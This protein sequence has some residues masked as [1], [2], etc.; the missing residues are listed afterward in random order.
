MLTGCST[1]VT[2][3]KDEPGANKAQQPSDASV[4][5]KD[6][7]SSRNQKW[8]DQACSRS[9]G[10]SLWARCV[11]RETRAL[12]DGV[13]DISQLSVENQDWISSSCPRSLGPS[14]A[15]RC[16]Q[17]EKEAVEAGIPDGSTLSQE[18]KNWLAQSCSKSLGPSLF[19]A[20]MNREIEALAKSD[21]L[22][23]R[24]PLQT[25]SPEQNELYEKHWNCSALL[26]GEVVVELAFKGD[27]GFVRILEQ[28]YEGRYDT[29]GTTRLWR[30]GDYPQEPEYYRY[31]IE[32][33]ARGIARLFDFSEL[34]TNG[35][36]RPKEALRC[37]RR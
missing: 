13:P 35:E 8:I 5:E 22:G 9:L 37:V 17:R 6:Y 20:C 18:Q 15:I 11:Q 10:P 31:L 30:F 2:T 33:N 28:E 25:E 32:L 7:L 3:L 16:M 29:D 21:S 34:G 14:L 24:T 1:T 26:G 19:R 36:V 4:G 12:N 27:S 23:I